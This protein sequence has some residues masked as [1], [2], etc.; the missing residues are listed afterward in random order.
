M[1]ELPH[2]TTRTRFPVNL[3]PLLYALVCKTVPWNS[4]RPSIS[5]CIA[6]AFSPVATISH[7]DTYSISTP[8]V[9]EVRVLTRHNRSCSSYSACTTVRLYVGHM[10]NLAA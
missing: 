6:S 7:R 10:P 1:P 4:C 8:I 9:P 3:L 2:P 5:G